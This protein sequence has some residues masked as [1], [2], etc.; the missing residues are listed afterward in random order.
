VRPLPASLAVALRGLAERRALTLGSV[1]VAAIAVAAAVVGPTYL[2]AASSSL[3]QERLASAP[4]LTTGLSWRFEPVRRALDDPAAVLAEAVAVAAEQADG[5]AP[6]L[7]QLTTRGLRVLHPEDQEAGYRSIRLMSPLDGCERLVVEGS[8][9]EAP[10][11]VLVSDVDAHPGAYRIGGTARGPAGMVFTVVGSYRPRD[12]ERLWFDVG[13]LASLPPAPATMTSEARPFT[14]GPFVVITEVFAELPA[15]SWWADVDRRLDVRSDL[16]VDDARTLAGVAEAAAAAA[17]VAG[18]TGDLAPA[19][20][21]GLVDVVAGVDDELATAR[22]TVLPAAASLTLIC[23]LLL[24]RLTGE[25]ADVR[26]PELALLSLRGWSRRRA[27]LFALAEPVLVLLIALP[28]G[29]A[30][31]WAATWALARWWLR[32]G[33][34]VALEGA[35]VATVG[36]VLLAGLLTAVAAVWQVLRLPLHG[37]LQGIRR[38]VATGRPLLALQVLL[39]VLTLAACAPLVTAERRTPGVLDLLLPVLLAV[40]AGLLAARL[41]LVAAAGLVRRGTGSTRPGVFVALRRLARR[42]E[43]TLVVLPLS[44]ALAVAVFAVSISG[45]AAAWRTSAAAS[46][47][48]AGQRFTNQLPLLENLAATRTADPDGRW[49]MAASVV[50]L[51]SEEPVTVVDVER[52]PAVAEW[53]RSW[54]DGTGAT[55]VSRLLGAQRPPVQVAGTELEVQVDAALESPDSLTLT[56]L[57]QGPDGRVDELWLPLRA[58]GEQTLAGTAEECADGCVLTGMRVAGVAGVTAHLAGELRVADITVDGDPVDAALDD[59]AAWRPPVPGGSAAT[60]E[61]EAA[62]AGLLLRVDTGDGTGTAHVHTT[63][64]PLRRPVL[65]APGA[66]LT[67]TGDGPTVRGAAVE[68]ELPVSVAGR[69]AAVPLLGDDGVLMD[70]QA[71]T[72]EEFAENELAVQSYVLARTGTPQRVLDDLAAAGAVAGPPLTLAE[73]VEHYEGDAY[74]LSLRLYGVVA[75][76]LVLL[77]LLSVVVHLVVGLPARRRDAASLRV[78]GVARGTVVRAAAIELTVVLGVASVAGVLGGFVGGALVTR[79]MVLGPPDVGLPAV[80]TASDPRVLAVFAAGSLLV[81]LVVGIA[82]A[83]AAVRGARVATLRRAGG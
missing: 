22:R 57:L 32:P 19:A 61:V 5:F 40:V 35:A 62:D 54:L 3:V 66:R 75:A 72:R 28:L 17:P 44:A 82:V 47:V 63:D 11:E 71:F 64:V 13:R 77:A 18:A 74:A 83:R 81:L 33:L 46:E 43:G 38:P 24:L 26:R 69:T 1:L 9:P 29:V 78:V 27:W 48:G 6:P 55:G 42:R 7:G 2:T 70:V 41:T 21:V 59:P 67:D 80:G 58:T 49:L 12:P 65:V 37:H 8:C 51:P 16:T 15:D 39:V 50:T 45:A 31:G 36:L 60:L 34:P 73:R 53:P 20:N 14:P 56:L 79:T 25:G 30:A 10:D 23:L 76:V 52:L 4:A 68:G